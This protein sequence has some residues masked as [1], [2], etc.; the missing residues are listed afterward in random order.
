MLTGSFDSNFHESG[1]FD[2]FVPPT[3]PHGYLDRIHV[4]ESA[5]RTGIGRAL[6]TAYVEEAAA[7]GCTFI[8]GSVD[9]S[10]E[11]TDRR[12]FFERLGFAVRDHDNFGARPSEILSTP[13]DR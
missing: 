5:R 10:S 3:A 8:G 9:L 12:A 1:A 13:T 7:Y 2:V 11:A 4:R 6:V